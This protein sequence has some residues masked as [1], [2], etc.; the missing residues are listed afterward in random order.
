MR[1]KTFDCVQMKRR[2]A[3]RIYEETKGMTLDEQI[4]Y[5]RKRTEEFRQWH[6]ALRNRGKTMTNPHRS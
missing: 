3:V 5:W 2:G 4:E 6:A 1:M